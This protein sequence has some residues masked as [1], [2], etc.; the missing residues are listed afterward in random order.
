[1]K[2]K[3]V[4]AFTAL[5]ISIQSFAQNPAYLK[6][7]EGLVS[8]I[9]T[10]QF[11]TPMQPLTNQME[12]IASAEKGEWL[13]NYWVA[14]C[15]MRDSYIETDGGKKDLILD[16]ADEYFKKAESLS[17]DNDE[18]EVLKANLA[19][20]RLVVSPQD[21]WQTYGAIVQAAV[22]KAKKINADNPRISLLEGEGMF[23]TPEQFGGGKSKAKVFFEKALDKYA[24]FTPKSTIYPSWGKE[25]TDWYISQCN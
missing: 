5:L 3:V 15:Y 8:K 12:R 10:T 19:N 11:G 22:E 16:K 25:T 23:Y 7:M 21:R 17:K 13:P 18:L 4:F 14:F 9:Q 1:M 6:T 2:R 24:K 20:A